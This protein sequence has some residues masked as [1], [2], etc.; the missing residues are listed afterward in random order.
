MKPK[1]VHKTKEQILMEKRWE[2]ENAP[3][4]KF[5]DETFM[6]LMEEI[7]QNLE[8][9]QFITESTK[10]AMN[11]AYAM[12]QKTMKV[13]E[14]KMIEQLKKVKKPEA[15]AKHVKVLEV[16]ADQ[17]IDDALRILDGLYDEANRVVMKEFKEKKLTDFKNGGSNTEQQPTNW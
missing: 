9:A 3:R 14:L 4:R 6:P 8:E 13:S 10:V 17:T 1:Q 11:Q 2:K 15:V 7:T 5:I 16:L 12:Q